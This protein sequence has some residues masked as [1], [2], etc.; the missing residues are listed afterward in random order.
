MTRLRMVELDDLELSVRSTNVLRAKGLTD[1]V[2]IYDFFKDRS[3]K[4]VMAELS[5]FGTKSYSEVREV[6]SWL[7]VDEKED[8]VAGW[9]DELE[10]IAQREVGHSEVRDIIQLSIAVSLKRIADRLD[11]HMAS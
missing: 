8:H 9:S 1:S 10:P 4:Q 6:I 7:M 5:G 11:A 2:L 3:R